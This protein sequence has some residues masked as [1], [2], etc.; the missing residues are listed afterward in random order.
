[1][2]AAMAAGM[3]ACSK[4]PAAEPAGTAS[5]TPFAITV[6]DAGYVPGAA[7]NGPATRA[8]ENGFRTEFAAGDRA[9]LY[10][11]GADGTVQHANVLVT[12]SAGDDGLTWSLPAGTSI[13]HFDG[14]RYFL[15]YPYQSEMTGKVMDTGSFSAETTAAEFFAP[16]IEDWIPQKNQSAEGYTGS[17]LMVGT[18]TVGA[19]SAHVV[20]LDFE[21]EHCMAL[22]LVEMPGEFYHITSYNS[23]ATA[24]DIYYSTQ[25][26]ATFEESVSLFKMNSEP[27]YRYIVRPGEALSVSGYYEDEE[28]RKWEFSVPEA[29]DG[30]KA[31]G[32]VAGTYM[33][34][35]VAGGAEVTEGDYHTDAKLVRI[36]DMFCPDAQNKDW[37]LI[38]YEVERIE[39]TDNVVGLVTINDHK[40]I[41]AAE[42]D[43]LGEDNVHGCVMA[44]KVPSRTNMG[45]ATSTEQHDHDLTNCATMAD[46]YEDI[47]GYANCQEIKKTNSDFSQ[48]P[49]FAAADGYNAECPLPEGKTSGWYLPAT[50]QVWS[51]LQE[52]GGAYQLG[53]RSEQTS[54]AE[55]NQSGD[56]QD[57][58][59]WTTTELMN[60]CNS[61]MALIPANKKTPFAVDGYYW[62]SSQRSKT[63][64]RFWNVGANGYL[65]CAF[66]SKTAIVGGWN[67]TYYVRPVFVF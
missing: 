27:Y 14:M 10:V 1:M 50:G 6:S 39:E 16:L 52:L 2:L 20:P 46:N 66:R 40:R 59:W 64:A 62:T 51:I 45:W 19:V 36:G 5:G 56:S 60:N 15:Y 3:L 47:N 37:Y 41:G 33:R 28:G 31:G 58:I 18:A 55:T 23:G 48:H 32:V 7:A 63:E 43:L 25:P 61:K 35:S 9:G 24:C 54:A 34:H 22:V 4:E 30:G 38:P 44:V 57:F 53:Y 13:A 26:A 17:D 12:A 11:I 49:A 8:V 65:R 42:K 29:E 21:I 67:E